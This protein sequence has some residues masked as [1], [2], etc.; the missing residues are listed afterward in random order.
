MTG[1]RLQT[2]TASIATEHER[3]EAER[4]LAMITG[5]EPEVL[6]Q[7][8][9]D[10]DGTADTYEIPLD[11]D[12]ADALDDGSTTVL[13]RCAGLPRCDLCNAE[14]TGYETRYGLACLPCRTAIAREDRGYNPT[15]GWSTR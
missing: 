15:T 11:E 3:D 13:V 7:I 1:Y 5:H 6:E 10:L 2:N 8:L 4:I 14:T 9:D 12:M